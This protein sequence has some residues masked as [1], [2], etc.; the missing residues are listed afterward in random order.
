[1][2]DMPVITLYESVSLILLCG[3]VTVMT[4]PV[5]M[6]CQNL[7]G[8]INCNPPVCKWI[9][10]LNSWTQS[11]HTVLLRR[12]L[13][14]QQFLHDE[15]I[16][17]HSKTWTDGC[18]LVCRCSGDPYTRLWIRYDLVFFAANVLVSSTKD[19]DCVR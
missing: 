9:L 13:P 18:F 2:G 16:V 8:D 1:M 4:R 12:T 7:L 17:P 14:M 19:W 6:M 15:A 5:G 10:I 11:N 3:A